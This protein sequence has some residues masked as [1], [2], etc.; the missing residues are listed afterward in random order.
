MCIEGQSAS[1]YL[2][3]LLQSLCSTNVMRHVDVD[4]IRAESSQQY[5]QLVDK[6]RTHVRTLEAAT[7]ALYDDGMTIFMAVQALGRV[8][9]LGARERASFVTTV[10][11]T[12]PIVRSNSLLVAQ[13]LESL[14][15]VGHDQAAISQGDYRNSIEWRASRINMA[16]SS[17]AALTSQLMAVANDDDE[18]VNME[19]AFMQPSM[20]VAPSTDSMSSQTM[21]SNMNQQ[22]SQSSLDMSDRSRSDSINEPETPTWTQS[23]SGEGTLLSPPSPDLGDEPLD[24]EVL[25]YVDEDERE[26]CTLYRWTRCSGLLFQRPSLASPLL[27]AL[28]RAT[29]S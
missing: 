25:P 28:A 16:D 26:L 10:E 11:S 2:S 23:E 29:S 15:A 17:I 5:M 1:A 9:L 18:Y 3:W 22:P 13:T 8:E 6:A 19:H 24:D 4:G 20:R 7:Q 21:Y 12:A 14:L 27:A